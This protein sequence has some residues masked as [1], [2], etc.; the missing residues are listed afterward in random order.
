MSSN[1]DKAVKEKFATKEQWLW[2]LGMYCL[3]TLVIGGVH[4]LIRA[5]VAWLK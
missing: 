4:L 3:S 2:F 5:F 1:T